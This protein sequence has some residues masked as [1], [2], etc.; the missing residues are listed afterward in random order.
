M[1]GAFPIFNFMSLDS[2]QDDDVRRLWTLR[3]FG[4]LELYLITL[5][6][7]FESIPLDGGEVNEDI[8]SIVS[9]NESEALLLVKPF[10]TTFGHYNSPPFISG[11]RKLQ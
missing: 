3:T 7:D 1:P 2:A 5:V 4:Y 8:I 6:K 9:G 11:I 10:N